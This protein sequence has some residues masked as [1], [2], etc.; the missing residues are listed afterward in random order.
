MRWVDVDKGKG[1]AEKEKHRS[2]L[3]AQQFNDGKGGEGQD[4]LFAATPPIESLKAI[5]SEAASKGR[6]SQDGTIGIKINDV[7]RAYFYARSLEPTYVELCEE[8][9]EPGEEDMC[10]RL[11][12]AMYGTRA[13]A[14]EWQSEFTT[15]LKSIK[16]KGGL[17]SPLHLQ[18]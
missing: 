13:A 12:Q 16:S 17:A 15:T 18:A 11:N 14:K 5:V 9:C 10:G 8:D 4:T 3:V 1:V 7:S 6:R 2:R